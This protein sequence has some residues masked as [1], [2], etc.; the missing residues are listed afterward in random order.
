MPLVHRPADAITLA[1]AL[2]A[3]TVAVAGPD[4]AGLVLVVVALALD[5]VD[6]QVARRTGTVSDFGARFD[7]ETD[8][9][10]ILVLSAYAVPEH[11]AWVLLIGLARY[12]LWLA[13]R[14]LPWLR[15]PVPP[16]YWRKVVA[17]VQGIVL[18]VAVSG[19][20]PTALATVAL[21][22]ALALLAESFGRDVWWLWRCRHGDEVPYPAGGGV[23]LVAAGA[24]WVALVLPASP[25]DLAQVPG[26]AAVLAAVAL[27]PRGRRPAAAVLGVLLA[28]L[29]VVRAMDVGFETFL[30]RPFDP[31]AD[32]SYLGPGIGVLGDSIGDAAAVATAVGAAVVV[33][34]L[35]VVL[36]L[37]TVRAS[38]ALARHRRPAVT[39]LAVCVLAPLAPVGSTGAA[40]LAY[41]EVRHARAELADR[42]SFA[43]EIA[44]DPY[45]G[46]PLRLEGLRGKDVLV[47]FVESYG[48]TALDLPGVVATV[49]DGTRRLDAAGWQSRSGFLTSP[50]FGAASWLAHS[51]LQSGLWV[52]SQ[53]RYDQLMAADR[54]TLTSAFEDAGWRTVFDVPANTRDWPEGAAFYGFD[55]LYDSRNVG[56]AGPEFGYA[57]VPDQYTLADL[58]RREL[59]GDPILGPV[60]AEVD[61]VSSH[62]PWT[63]PPAPVAWDRVGDGS[64]LTEPEETLDDVVDRYGRGIEYSLHTLVSW[65]ARYRGRDLVVLVL[66][67]HQPHSYVTGPDP[68]HDVPVSVIARDPAVIRRIGG[69]DWQPGLHP[70][71]TAPVWPM[72]VVRDEVLDAFS[73]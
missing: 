33:A 59:T 39:L 30:D 67:D 56:Y 47:V 60:F 53:G 73:R 8:A 32:W 17:A 9:F 64:V 3:V 68:G 38:G 36:P 63:P 16:R 6:G 48:R 61:L 34:A 58:E 20:V 52:D 15:K 27:L 1:R 45:A 7:M 11:G 35:L 69:W 22:V 51:T 55:Q 28:L 24:V 41:D 46:V 62:H 19:L 54:L 44:A 49:D 37:A 5:W 40:G 42:R 10:L 50:T 18:A 2:L 65:L 66:G 43:A 4:G 29:G 70:D 23:T 31:V 14:V 71:G 57:P 21:L 72:D 12:L 13:E 25:G 26:A